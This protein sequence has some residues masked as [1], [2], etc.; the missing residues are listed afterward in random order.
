[1][2][3]EELGQVSEVPQILEHAGMG[4]YFLAY[5]EAVEMPWASS[6]TTSTTTALRYRKARAVEFFNLGAQLAL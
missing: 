4:D 5:V 1:M 3:N 2:F 6:T